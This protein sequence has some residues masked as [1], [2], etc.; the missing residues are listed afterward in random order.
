MLDNEKKRNEISD[1]NRA[2][3]M[4][5][6]K[7]SDIQNGN[8]NAAIEKITS[9]IAK[10]IHASRCSIWAYDST[11]Y[12]IVS[13][14][15]Y[16]NSTGAFESG[17]E[18]FGRDFPGYFEAVTSEEV[19]VAID[20]HTHPATR[21]FSDVYLTPLSIYSLLDVPYF[22]EGKIAGVICCEHQNEQK[23]WTEQDIEFLKS[24]A[25]LVTVAFN[26]MKI[27]NMVGSLG[28]AKETMQ[29][30]IDNL[31]RAVFW[32]DK[33]L[34]FQGCNRIF[35]DVA[36]LKSPQDLIGKTDYEM[37]WKEHG[38]AYRADD[39]SVMN[40]RKAR[41]DQEERNTDSNGKESW[42]LTSKVPVISKTGDVVAVLGMFEDITDRKLKET[43]V[44]SKLA[45][46]EK[47]KKLLEKQSN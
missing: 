27:N 28:D 13:E 44:A 35:A 25:D 19:I 21:E 7:N 16:Q 32:K 17:T 22:N 18:L 26:T 10:Q 12:K 47:L 23:E 41:L 29:A 3:V 31:P 30:I 45:E 15:L 40:S 46:L 14:K 20:A 11:E 43:D 5:L 38:D 4:E 37:P 9:T 8:W 24:C 33:D 42:V 34:K 39:L 2:V 1:K 6:T 36:G